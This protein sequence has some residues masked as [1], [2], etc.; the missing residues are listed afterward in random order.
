MKNKILPI[1]IAFAA[2]VFAACESKPA[3]TTERETVKAE[4]VKTYQEI[5]KSEETTDTF[6]VALY[7]TKYTFKYLIKI[8]FKG[9]ETTDSLRIPNLGYEPQPEIK[10]GEVRPSCIIGFLDDKK[11][12][13]EANEVLFKD[14]QLLYHPLKSYDVSE[15]K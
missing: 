12:F 10:Q 13:M 9:I 4:P 14:N 1:V 5:V 11:Q 3:I 7:E 6:N 2:M 8:S 15:E